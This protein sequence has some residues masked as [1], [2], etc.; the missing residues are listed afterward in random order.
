PG[1]EDVF[2]PRT[3]G[4][5]DV[6]TVTTVQY[7]LTPA[8]RARLGGSVDVELRSFNTWTD[9]VGERIA[10]VD[11]AYFGEHAFRLSRAPAP[12][13]WTAEVVRSETRYESALPPTAT[14][15]AGRLGI[16]YAWVPT[17][18]TSVRAG[19]EKT[20]LV[21]RDREQAIYGAGLRW[22]PS[23]RTL[24]E[25]FGERRFFG[26]G[27]SARFDHRWPRLAW[28]LVSRRD[29]GSFPQAF[30]T[31]PPTENVVALLNA[32]LTTRVP[33]EFERNRVIADILARYNLPASLVT[34]TALYSRRFSIQT[35]HTASLAVIGVRNSLALTV[36]QTTTEDLR[37]AAFVVPTGLPTNVKQQ[38]QAATL[39]HLVTPLTTLN[40][41][42]T[43][44][45]VE[46]IG[47]DA[48]PQSRQTGARLEIAQRLAPRSRGFAGVRWQKF[49]SKDV[50]AAAD[51][52]ER[53]A[54]VGLAHRF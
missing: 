21:V 32:A 45:R 5:S 4:P 19:Y 40:L 38:G 7:R 17:F 9:R 16:E 3:D 51:A 29:V 25:A 10:P 46:G 2:G 52:T 14:T 39:A 12:F 34:P 41:T 49:E 23:E 47:V 22:R 31:L 37:D 27:W 15:D 35:A 11:A 50:A 42:L 53:A 1:A 18:T 43:R 30:L 48:G 6:N 20:D 26:T 13:G 36:F 33:D 44:T 8:L 54:Y 24:L 28:S